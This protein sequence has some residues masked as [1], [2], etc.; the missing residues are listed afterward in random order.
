MTKTDVRIEKK[1]LRSSYITSTLSIS[2][3]L[4]LLGLVCLMLLN[5]KRLSDYVKE[6]IGFSVILKDNIKEVDIIRL[7][8]SLDAKI[9]VKSTEY[10]TKEQAAEETKQALGEDFVEFLGTNPLPAS[11][12]V[13][14][15]ASYANPDSI[16]K[17]ESLF[18]GNELVK[19]VSYQKNLVHLVNENVKKISFFILIVSALLFLIAFTL[20]NNTIRLAVY[21]KRFIINTMQLVGANHSFIRKP[22]MLN[23]ILHGVYGALMAI[24]YL[25]GF[26]YFIEKELKQYLSV[27]DYKSV[28]ALFTIVIIMGILIT[29]ISTFFAVN[30][31]LRMRTDDLYY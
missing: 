23:S 28:G 9:Y 27:S 14:L 3:V 12:E 15:F 18:K 10:I 8:K 13:K 21:A 31:Y 16:V 22:F 29:S 19:E 6:N 2:L 17:I 24:L 26:I 11:I 5:T 7:K 4:F 20:I 25:T 1:R 30:R